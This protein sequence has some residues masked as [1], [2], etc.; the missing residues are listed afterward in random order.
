MSDEALY[1]L[2][3]HDE[4]HHTMRVRG[5]EVDQDEYLVDQVS[6]PRRRERDPVSTDP[7]VSQMLQ[8]QQQLQAQMMQLMAQQNQTANQLQAVLD[9]L[10]SDRAVR[11]RFGPSTR[12]N[13]RDSSCFFL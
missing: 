12:P 13:P 3:E 7:L 10:P 1:L 5:A 11:P 8:T 2:R 4:R 9:R 6:V